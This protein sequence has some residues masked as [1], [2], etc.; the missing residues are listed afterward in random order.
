VLA[1]LT[2]FLNNAPVTHC[3][4]N[5]RTPTHCVE[6]ASDLL[7][8]IS[9]AL[10]TSADIRQ[11]I[12]AYVFSALLIHAITAAC[13]PVLHSCRLAALTRYRNISFAARRRT[14]ACLACSHCRGRC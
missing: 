8:G 6:R 5:V 2:L 13:L 7:R 4:A 12:H 11:L 14:A 10:L 3:P 1:R 9:F